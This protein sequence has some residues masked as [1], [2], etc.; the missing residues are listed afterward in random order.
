MKT[1]IVKA[2][3][4]ENVDAAGA[5]G[6]SLAA[7]ATVKLWHVGHAVLVEQAGRRDRLIPMSNV[8][9]VELVEAYASAKP[10]AEVR[11]EGSPGLEATSQEWV[12]SELEKIKNTEPVA[13]MPVKRGPGRPAKVQP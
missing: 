4:I 1:P 13:V 9:E 8:A 10:W 5:F 6:K 2:R 7:N 11:R 12:M 3:F